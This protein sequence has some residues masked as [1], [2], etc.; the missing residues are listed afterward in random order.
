MVEAI[1]QSD[2]IAV[3][4][5]TNAED[6]RDGSG[7]GIGISIACSPNSSNIIFAEYFPYRHVTLDDKDYRGN[8]SKEDREALRDCIESFKGSIIFHNA[9]FDLCSLS[10]MDINYK[11]NFYCTLLMSH[12]INENYPYSKSLN[13]CVAAYVDKNEAKKEEELEKAV[14]AFGW[15]KVPFEIMRPYATYDA[16]LTLELFKVL[17]KYFDEENLEEYWKHKQEFIRTIIGMESRGIKVDVSLCKELTEIGTS[18]LADLTYELSG[19]PGSS[20]FL[21]KILIDELKLPVVKR[22]PKT[23]APSFDKEAMTIYDE[24]LEHHNNPTANL[25]KQYRGWQ[26][27]VTSNYL[28]YVE[29]LSLDGRLRPNYKLHGTKTGRMS[30]EKPNLQQ[31]PRVSDKPW[32]G[33]M[34]AAFIPED[35]FELWEFDYCVSPDTKLLGTDLIWY[36]ADEVVEGQELI[37]FDENLSRSICKMKPTLVTATGRLKKQGMRIHLSNGDILTCSDNHMWSVT[38]KRGQQIR[39][40]RKTSDLSFGDRLLKYVDSPWETESSFDAGYL[41]GVYDGEGYITGGGVGFGQKSGS[42]FDKV[43][44]LL[45]YYGFNYYNDYAYISGMN[46]ILIAKARE[47]LRFLGQFRPVRLL[48]KARTIWE[49][50]SPYGKFNDTPYV[51]RTE[52]IGEIDVI[53]VETTEHTFIADGY[54]SHNCQLELRLGTAYAKEETLKRVFADD[55]DIFSE[56]AATIGMSRQD[57]KTLV[58]TTQYGGGISR[59]SH[60][61][62]VSEARAAEL[63][64]QYFDSYPGFAIIGRYASNMCKQKGKIRLWSNRYRHF[65]SKKDDAHKAFNS[66][67]Q[68]GAADIVEHVMVRLFKEVDDQDKCRMLLQVHDSIV[69]EIRKD[70][71][72]EYKQKI[73][74][75]MSDIKPDFGVKFAVDAHRW[76]E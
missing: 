41:S 62:G 73:L 21:K 12:L 16:V 48:P 60:V 2:V 76:G 56:M 46:K 55:R 24:I 39:Q 42:V 40:W 71:L 10:T 18:V 35:G 7:Y 45:E 65:Q 25:I 37:G 69:F 14:A 38:P 53:A 19:N 11:G 61:F 5:E 49:S 64:Q 30:C 13:A 28:P 74:T 6:I 52:Y 58:Y 17:K 26:K 54:M 47:S 70:C 33:K 72:E 57:T 67:I 44:D 75:I 51:V 23:G 9:K 31:I 59:I 27:S 22:S 15:A 4:T 68:G 29:L 66:V 3:D 32:N 50:R 36:R 63:R 8:L 20:I 43:T 1:K 34:K